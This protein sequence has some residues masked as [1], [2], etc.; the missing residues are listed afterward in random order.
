LYRDSPKLY[1]VR[2]DGLGYVFGLDE[3]ECMKGLIGSSRI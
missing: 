3:C 1:F 2:N